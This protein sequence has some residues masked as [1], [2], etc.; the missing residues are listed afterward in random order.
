MKLRKLITMGLAAVMAVSVSNI[1]T[2]A[3]YTTDENIYATNTMDDILLEHHEAIMNLNSSGVTLA[4][5]ND[6]TSVSQIQANTVLTLNEAG[7]EA[8]DVNPR[9]FETVEE[10]LNTDLEDAGLK[11]EYYYIVIIGDEETDS[12]ISPQSTISSEFTHTYNGETY[13]M[14]WMT[15]TASDDPQMGKASYSNVLSSKSETV[16]KNCLSAS[17]STY[18]SSL[19]TTTKVLGTVAS[20]C[21]LN[22]SDFNTAQESTMLLNAGTNW[23][24]RYTQVF[25]DSLGWKYGC[26]VEEV[27]AFSYMSGSYY[28]ASLNR[29]ENVPEAKKYDTRY[30]SHFNDMQWRKD[31]AAIGL[32]SGIVKNAVGDVQ[33]KYNGTTKI[34]HRENF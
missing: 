23:T 10:I 31:S 12:E 29:Y 30:S 17:I 11:P 8:Y 18:L 16:I 15:V 2:L 32:N 25:S 20:I 6:S 7:Y 4:S 34:T 13:R 33:Y 3:A 27:T 19:S 22:I 21:G 26:Y 5:T 9:T 28:S 24:R 14:R 1:N